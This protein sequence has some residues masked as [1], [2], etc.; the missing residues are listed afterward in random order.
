MFIA[1]YKTIMFLSSKHLNN[2]NGNMGD[3]ERVPKSVVSISLGGF[4]NGFP[5]DAES[6]MY[7]NETRD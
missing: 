2:F 6:C 7:L 3:A 5:A 1:S 4:W